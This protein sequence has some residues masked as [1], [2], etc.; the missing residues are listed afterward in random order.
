MFII[1]RWTIKVTTSTV[2]AMGSAAV[3][4]KLLKKIYPNLAIWTIKKELLLWQTFTRSQSHS[5]LVVYTLEE[6]KSFK[7]TQGIYQIVASEILS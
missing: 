1:Y 4:L 3:L 2:L 6:D 7:I 5:A